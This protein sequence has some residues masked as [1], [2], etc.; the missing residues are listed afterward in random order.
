MKMREENGKLYLILVILAMSF[1]VDLIINISS[2]NTVDRMVD[3]VRFELTHF[4]L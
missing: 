1:F 2:H 3:E 4:W